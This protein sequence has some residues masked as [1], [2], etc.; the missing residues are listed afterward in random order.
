MQFSKKPKNICQFFTAFL[1]S[2][3]HEMSLR[4]SELKYF[5]NYLFRKTW[6]RKCLKG[7]VSE[8]PLIVNGLMGSQC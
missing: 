6:L 8:Y 1:E 7:P 4:A 2:I 3:K 5:R